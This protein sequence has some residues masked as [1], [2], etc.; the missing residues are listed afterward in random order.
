[1]SALL[2]V[3]D[4]RVAYGRTVAL[5]GVSLSVAAG[6]VV[7]RVGANRSGKTTLLRAISGL[8]AL[9]RGR[10]TGGRILYDGELLMGDAAARVRAGIVHV[11]EGRRVFAELSV[12]D[13]L[14]SGAFTAPRAGRDDRLRW[15][16]ERFPVLAARQGLRAG[17]L[18]GGEQQLL[19]IGRALM[20]SP[21]LLLLDEPTLGLA[22]ASVDRVA[23]VVREVAAGGTAVLVTEQQPVL[24]AVSRV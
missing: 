16:L 5:D 18:S 1:M 6:S 21:R 2:A 14:R 15:V 12:E 23:E 13:N 17:H 9:H 24:E 20:A 19:A 22:R 3:D 10:V 8:L 7:S 4:L 11:L